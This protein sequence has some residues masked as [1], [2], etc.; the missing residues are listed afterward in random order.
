MHAAQETFTNLHGV[1]GS[2]RLVAR[3]LE[4]QRQTASSASAKPPASNADAHDGLAQNRD[5][6]D[7]WLADAL[8]AVPDPLGLTPLDPHGRFSPDDLVSLPVVDDTS[9]ADI[10]PRSPR[11]DPL[12]GCS[13]DE[14]LSLPVPELDD[15]SCIDVLPDLCSQ[16]LRGLSPA[17]ALSSVTPSLPS[18]GAVGI[19]ILPSFSEETPTVVQQQATTADRGGTFIL[20]GRQTK[21]Q[22]PGQQESIAEAF[23]GTGAPQA[24]RVDRDPPPQ[25][26]L[27]GM[28]ISGRNN[29]G[30]AAGPGLPGGGISTSSEQLQK[31][32][33]P[34]FPLPMLRCS[35][36]CDE[37]TPSSLTAC[38]PGSNHN[39]AHSHV[40]GLYSD[41]ESSSLHTVPGLGL[42]V[43]PNLGAKPAVG[44]HV[45][46][47]PVDKSA[48]L[49]HQLMG[50]VVSSL[51]GQGVSVSVPH[52][53]PEHSKENESQRLQL[54]GP[55]LPQL[56]MGQ[57]ESQLLQLLTSLA[58]PASGSHKDLPQDRLPV[59]QEINRLRGV[60]ARSPK[61]RALHSRNLQVNHFP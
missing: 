20:P 41:K 21:S 24:E 13:P 4:S 44:P 40:T 53:G 5:D 2:I 27:P 38:P 30:I 34:G 12:E 31:Q 14:L 45:S 58:Q 49:L 11:E 18:Q 7:D 51:R 17:S 26:V 29:A 22:Q 56:M 6:Y 1:A 43:P 32:A 52:T 3:E 48:K 28:V 50:D 33:T 8:T 55:M 15:I 25:T 59:L 16:G 54:S 47:V 42:I 35:P 61:Y 57:H 46:G 36:P 9:C 37:A 10:L 60:A 23:R 19:N 39:H